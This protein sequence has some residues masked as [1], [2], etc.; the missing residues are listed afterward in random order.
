MSF[1]KHDV[2]YDR[3]PILLC[4][5]VKEMEYVGTSN[6]KSSHAH[7][8]ANQLL[9][10]GKRF[11]WRH[12]KSIIVTSLALTLVIVIVLQARKQWLRLKQQ[13]NCK[14]VNP[15]ETI[16]VGL[17]CRDSYQSAKVVEAMLNSAYCHKRLVFSVIVV[18]VDQRLTEQ[19][20]RNHI[21]PH[22]LVLQTR[23]NKV[24]E[25]LIKLSRFAR[26]VEV[27][28]LLVSETMADDNTELVHRGRSCIESLFKHKSTYVMHVE[29]GCTLPQH[30][31]QHLIEQMKQHNDESLIFTQIPTQGNDRSLSW[32]RLSSIVSLDMSTGRTALI[33]S[34]EAESTPRSNPFSGQQITVPLFES[35]DNHEPTKP[36]HPYVRPHTRRSTAKGQPLGQ[37][38]HWSGGFSFGHASMWSSCRHEPSHS[39][40]YQPSSVYDYVMTVRYWNQGY[41]FVRPNF[42]LQSNGNA[43]D[44]LSISRP[45]DRQR[46]VEDYDALD[47][48]PWFHQLR[49]PE[50]TGHYWRWLV[51]NDQDTSFI[52]ARVGLAHEAPMEDIAHKFGNQTM[53]DQIM[54]LSQ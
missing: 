29:D 11:A 13:V 53:Y 14:N 47:S 28:E 48:Q 30:W 9:A 17:V 50:W 3:L 51:G 15:D 44:T 31:D 6:S 19:K 2:A 36:L 4:I 25:H 22:S 42:S 23:S 39:F 52:H 21:V 43:K 45:F 27:N 5:D 49:N 16:T 37:Q 46:G 20:M 8:K 38:L 10:N 54:H 7:K 40:R 41:R 24:I 35:F 32:S 1:N 26:Q 34:E 33:Q 12:K 18:K